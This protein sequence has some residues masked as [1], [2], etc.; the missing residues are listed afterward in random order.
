VSTGILEPVPA[1]VYERTLDVLQERGWCQGIDED[2]DGHVCLAGALGIALR[3]YQ[4]QQGTQRLFDYS[5]LYAAVGSDSVVG[6]NDDQATTF[7]DVALWLKQA[8]E[9]ARTGTQGRTGTQE[10]GVLR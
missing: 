6:R 10:Q 9:I 2:T 7:E 1:A 5:A 8:A 4:R 3:E